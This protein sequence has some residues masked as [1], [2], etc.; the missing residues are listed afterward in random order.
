MDPLLVRAL[1]LVLAAQPA[2]ALTGSANCTGR[3]DLQGNSKGKA[4]E[5]ELGGPFLASQVSQNVAVV[6]HIPP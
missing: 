5:C 2:V 6:A 3:S 1:L 4:L